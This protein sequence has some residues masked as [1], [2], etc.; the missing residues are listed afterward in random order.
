MCFRKP[1]DCGGL[2]DS[3]LL[4]SEEQ[5][6]MPRSCVGM[7]SFTMGLS[8]PISIVLVGLRC[9]PMPHFLPLE[10]EVHIAF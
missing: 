3:G 5:T 10:F 2:G 1:K 6:V 4:G 8:L 9:Q 7:I